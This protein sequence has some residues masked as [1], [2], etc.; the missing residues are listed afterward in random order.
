MNGETPELPGFFVEWRDGFGQDAADF[1]PLDFVNQEQAVPF[2]IAARWLFCPDFVEYRDCVVVVKNR[3]VE[4]PRL[5]PHAR[6]SSTTGSVPS[7]ATARR[8]RPRSTC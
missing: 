1:S 4:G 3:A 8:S 2:V 6:R 7:A 5:A